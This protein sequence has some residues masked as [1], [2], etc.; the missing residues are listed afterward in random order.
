[1]DT[2]SGKLDGHFDR[3]MDE[4]ARRIHFTRLRSRARLDMGG[5]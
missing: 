4:S 2:P 5:T 1:M 3:W